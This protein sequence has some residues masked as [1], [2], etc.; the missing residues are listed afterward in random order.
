MTKNE[1][2][3]RLHF[4]A[5]WR[6]LDF[7]PDEL[8]GIQLAEF[9]PEHVESSEHTRNGAFSWWLHQNPTVDALKKLA[10]LS[11][12]DPDKHLSADVQIRIRASKHYTNAV[13]EILGAGDAKGESIK[14]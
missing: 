2:L 10:Q 1:F 13:E 7:Y 12:A 11:L 14:P 8:F 6:T 4:P 9:R 3:D 5:E